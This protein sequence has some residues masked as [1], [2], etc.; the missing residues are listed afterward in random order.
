M[1]DALAAAG[2]QLAVV[3]AN[4]ESTIRK[5]LGS[6]ARHISHISGGVVAVR[7]ARQAAAHEPPVRNRTRRGH[8]DR[9]RDPR[10]Q[11]RQ[12]RA[13]GLRRRVLGH[14][15]PEALGAGGADVVF[16]RMADIPGVVLGA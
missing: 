4:G 8:R 11:R 2:L 9:R 3:S 6:H 5:V 12:G 16:P 1:I 10:P 13:H 7:Q 15:R 14:D